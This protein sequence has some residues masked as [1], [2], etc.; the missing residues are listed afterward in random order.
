M[1][2]KREGNFTKSDAGIL[3]LRLANHLTMFFCTF[4]CLSIN[5]TYHI[6]CHQNLQKIKF[7]HILAP[8]MVKYND[9]GTRNSFFSPQLLLAEKNTSSG[10]V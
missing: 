2:T 1:Y 3:C 6:S 4:Q 7:S 10:E 9:S 5:F 8:N